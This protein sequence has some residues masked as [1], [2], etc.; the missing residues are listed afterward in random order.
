MEV[1]GCLAGITHTKSGRE[2][3]VSMSWPAMLAWGLNNVDNLKRY[4]RA[5]FINSVLSVKTF[6]ELLYH[7]ETGGFGNSGL[8]G[9]CTCTAELTL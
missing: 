4:H 5:D 6:E 9:T 3:Y 2:R 1:N 8:P 7:M